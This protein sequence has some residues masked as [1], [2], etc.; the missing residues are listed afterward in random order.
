MRQSHHALNR[1]VLTHPH[2]QRPRSSTY[3][4][5]RTVVMEN[6]PDPQISIS[7]PSMIT[8]SGLSPSLKIGRMEDPTRPID[9]S[10]D[11]DVVD[12]SIESTYLFELNLLMVLLCVA[13]IPSSEESTTCS[14]SDKKIDGDSQRR[15]STPS[16]R[17]SK[18]R[19]EGVNGFQLEQRR[20]SF[21][22][23]ARDIRR[24]VVVGIQEK[25]EDEVGWD[26][27]VKKSSSISTSTSSA[28]K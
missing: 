6:K 13:S 22:M 7:S 17:K 26:R 20:P 1:A 2:N 10:E 9:V 3:S 5:T 16:P 21:Q 8:G 11:G 19:R 4:T 27:I 23:K 24:I 14:D 25:C 28:H 15:L 18:R 12:S